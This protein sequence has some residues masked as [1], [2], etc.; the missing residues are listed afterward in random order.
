MKIKPKKDCEHC[1]ETGIVE[2]QVPYG[3]GC[4]SLESYCDCIEEQIPEDYDG[5][6]EIEA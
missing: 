4:A 1:H 5:D 2:D 3:M 6:I